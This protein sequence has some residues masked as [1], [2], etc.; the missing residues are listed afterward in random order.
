MNFVDTLDIMGTAVRLI[1]CITGSGAPTAE[2]DGDV[3]V[4]YLD[5]TG[6]TIYACTDGGV[7]KPL[8]VSVDSA[9][10]D[11]SENPVQN[12]AVKAAI[13]AKIDKTAATT[14]TFAAD[15]LPFRGTDGNF[16][17]GAPTSDNQAAT[18]KYVDDAVAA[19][20][21]SV[22]VDSAL[23]DTSEN[24]VQNKVVKA[25]L[26]GKVSCQPTGSGE[27]GVYGMK[28]GQEQFIKYTRSDDPNTL[29]YRDSN[30]FFVVHTPT[31]E[32]HPTN[33]K[34]VDDAIAGV[35]SGGGV[36]TFYTTTKN[37][38]KSF[39]TANN[40][41]VVVYGSVGYSAGSNP[42]T[43]TIPLDAFS[44][45][46]AYNYTFRVLAP[47]SLADTGDNGSSQGATPFI[48][49]TMTEGTDSYTLSASAEN[50][51]GVSV[52]MRSLYGIG[53]AKSGS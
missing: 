45:S 53:T 48:Q 33:K 9:L 4:L 37:V 35:S 12:K 43:A 7:W 15:T 14:D 28:D 44:E 23:S 51:G 8:T 46:S 17:I 25:A 41:V 16:S 50:F 29:V 49:I 18:K 1:P 26:D 22:A 21:G 13:D 52:V 24:P 34:Y 31:G 6:G 20:G 42:W 47:T 36:N 40:G 2:T 10:S 3:G 19:S 27:S 11:S 32:W 38:P 5:K 30:G 39:V